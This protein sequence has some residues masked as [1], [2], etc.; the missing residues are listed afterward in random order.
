MQEC[1][2]TFYYLWSLLQQLN[3]RVNFRNPTFMKVYVYFNFNW[4]LFSFGNLWFYYS[5]VFSCCNYQYDLV[6]YFELKYQKVYNYNTFQWIY[7]V[8]KY[9]ITKRLS[10]RFN[11]KFVDSFMQLTDSCYA[12]FGKKENKQRSDNKVIFCKN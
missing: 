2:N 9:E 3:I 12:T 1:T 10:I 5:V 4:N 11:T 8:G 6:Q 7:I